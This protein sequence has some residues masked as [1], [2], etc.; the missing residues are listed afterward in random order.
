MISLRKLPT[1]KELFL[2]QLQEQSK[3]SSKRGLPFLYSMRLIDDI[4][5]MYWT[6]L[7]SAHSVY[8]KREF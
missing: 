7:Y 4:D 5:Y 3:P 1:C 6:S 8:G 2:A